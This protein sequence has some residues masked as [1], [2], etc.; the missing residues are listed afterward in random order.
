L[1]NK[2][3]SRKNTILV[4]VIAVAAAILSFVSYE[5]SIAVADLILE[6]GPSEARSTTEVQTLPELTS[7]IV[8]LVNQQ[9][10]LNIIL[11]ISFGV[12]AVVISAH[13]LKSNKKLSKMIVVKISE[14]KFANESFAESNR[15]LQI[16]NS[17]LESSNN[18]LAQA[19]EDL[20]LHDKLQQEFVNIAAH[21]LRTPIQP[22]LGA[23]ELMESQFNENDEIKITK[24]EIE[25][26]LRNAKR[27]ERLSSDILEISRIDS[28]TLKINKETFSL[29]YIIAN[30][31][32][33][34]KTQ[35]NFDPDRVT[36]TYRPDDIFVHADREKITEVITNLITNAIKFTEH[37]TISI[38]TSKDIANGVVI[39][40]VVD[41]GSGIDPEIMSKLF[42]K[43]VTKSEK[44]TG[45]GLYIS[46]K[47][48]EAHGG[49]I[50]GENNLEGHGATFKFS[51]P[52]M[53]EQDARKDDENTTTSQYSAAKARM[54]TSSLDN[55][56]TP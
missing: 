44:G 26:I 4:A 19:N 5:Y 42:E 51:V 40:T 36:I 38:T 1:P 54:G 45:I 39:V 55:T 15:Q 34:A 52:L 47:I 48:I 27:L 18:L 13:L 24:P 9:R 12:V 50:S 53:Q 41:T 8:G 56:S 3:S 17:K 37:G 29:A 30:A 16:A 22:L 14:L 21:E 35:S 2:Y 31:V 10:V 33:D 46:R 32:K 25:L 11:I 7:N 49:T 23:A 43:F 6:N 28:G 20:R